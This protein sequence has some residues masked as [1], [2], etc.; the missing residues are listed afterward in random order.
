MAVSAHRALLADADSL[1]RGDLDRRGN[2]SEQALVAWADYVLDTCLGPIRFMAGLLDSEA[3]K[4]RIEASLV[5]EATVCKQGVPRRPARPALPVFEWRR[6]A[7]WRLQGHARHEQPWRH[8]CAGRAGQAQPAQVG[9][10]TG[11]GALWFAAACVALYL[12]AAVVRGGADS[13]NIC[14]LNGRLAPH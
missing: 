11:L 4:T 12:P 6:N 2:L 8:R 10:A 9:R 1:R 5:F 13:T 3:I 14:W 7:V